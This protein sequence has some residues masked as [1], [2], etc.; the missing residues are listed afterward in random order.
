MLRTMIRKTHEA[1]LRGSVAGVPALLQPVAHALLQAGEDVAA[2]ARQIPDERLWTRPGGVASAGFHLQHLTGVIDRLFT[3]ARGEGL[4]DEQLAASRAEGAPADPP[5][6][7][8]QLVERFHRQ[9]ELAIEQLRQTGEDELL[10]ARGV[11]RARLP[12]TVLG[13]LFHAAEHTQRHVGQLLVTVRVQA[14]VTGR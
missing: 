12:S 4:T 6:D 1:W 13:L 14:P 5:P 9:I 7:A 8:A 2:L 10:A 3:Y 11:G